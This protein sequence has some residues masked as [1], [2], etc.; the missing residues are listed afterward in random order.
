MAYIQEMAIEGASPALRDAYDRE[1]R[2]A[3]GRRGRRWSPA[4]LAIADARAGYD[5]APRTGALTTGA[6]RAT[7]SARAER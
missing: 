3:H 2:R 5:D 1:G 6:G 7:N 4:S